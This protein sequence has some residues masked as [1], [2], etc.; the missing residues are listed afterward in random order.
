MV[1]LIRELD[2]FLET[3]LFEY[4]WQLLAFCVVLPTL[5]FVFR[6]LS[7]FVSQISHLSNTFAFG[8][9]FSG[10]L[11]VYVFARLFGRAVIWKALMTEEKY[12]RSVKDVAE[13][14]IELLGYT[15]ILM[16]T[17]ELFLLCLPSPND[18]LE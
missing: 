3:H 6:N 11:V 16:G 12:M 17:I 8:L 4:A 18:P 9:L 1:S 7:R 15:I 5:W 2:G 13:E 14:G 10:T